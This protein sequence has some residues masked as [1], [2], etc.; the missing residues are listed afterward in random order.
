M[1]PSI[2]ITPNQYGV[3]KLLSI[4]PTDGAGDLDV[5]RAT[6][7]T[8]VDAN[9]LIEIARTNL[10]LRSEEF[11][12]SPW[13]TLG[14]I[15]ITPNAINSPNGTLT[16]DLIL[17]ADGI[18]SVNQIISGT[19]GFVYTNSFYI[20]N[21][22]STQSRLTIRN[23]ITTLECNINW[24]GNT[25]SGITNLTGVT[26]FQDVGDGWYRIIS[27]YTALEAAQRPRVLPTLTTN[28]SVYVWGAQLESGSTATEYIPTTTSIRTRFAGITQDGSSASNIP[29]L[30]YTNGSC[31]SIL[32][33]P[34]R[35]NLLLRSEEFDNAYWIKGNL[36]TVSVNSTA[37]PDGNNT[38]D[39]HV[40]PAITG[41]A[42]ALV[43]INESVTINL[44]YTFSVFL[45][46]SEVRFIQ[47]RTNINGNQFCNFD[48][49][50]GIAGTPTTNTT[51]SIV[52]YGNG[53]YRCSIT[54]TAS[55]SSSTGSYGI[56]MCNSILDGFAP[57]YTGTG[58]SGY[59]IWGAQLEVGSNATSY[60]K[61]EATA[62]TRNADVI[63]KT[64]ISDLI[65]QTE[66]TL[67]VDFMLTSLANQGLFS[68]SNNSTLT[69]EVSLNIVSE[70]IILTAGYGPIMVINVSGAS[71]NTRYKVAIR[72]K[73]N[74]MAMTINGVLYKNT[75]F[76]FPASV[77]LNTFRH[78]SSAAG[79]VQGLNVKLTSVL[80]TALSDTELIQLT[81][82]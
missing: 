43:R 8:R 71:L 39:K 52:N 9:G 13:G 16:A 76:A 34:Q 6:S 33:E 80:K 55:S 35:T 22:N 10:L 36:S 73:N 46:Q 65:G 57:I 54:T 69:G 60:I 24:S 67:F 23:A 26:T 82:L 4:I 19:I 59:L 1:N 63:S 31:P 7:A 50:L 27:T 5:V 42:Y 48:L 56:N 14:T 32:V 25:L 74:D 37:S 11:N 44:I 64:G 61:T 75:V 68:L 78:G 53:W 30:D 21:N 12:V 40:S 45:K 62:V 15:T 3:G 51:P 66:G 2:L 49:Q 70:A 41:N 47:L 17:G 72:Y 79:F 38:A 18:S 58:N 77:E 81:T 20:K 29:R 28:Q